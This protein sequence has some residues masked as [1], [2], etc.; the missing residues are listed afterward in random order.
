VTNTNS[1]TTSDL[2]KIALRLLRLANYF[3]TRKLKS[4]VRSLVGVLFL[5]G[6][7]FWFLPIL[8]LWMFPVGLLLIALDIPAFRRP[9]R[10]WLLKWKQKILHH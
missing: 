1:T 6:G 4:G 7:V 9:A 8:G 5:I 3:G 10:Q 2:Q